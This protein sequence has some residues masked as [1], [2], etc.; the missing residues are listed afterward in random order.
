MFHEKLDINVIDSHIHIM[1]GIENFEYL[2]NQK[3]TYGYEKV[4]IL[5]IQPMGDLSQNAKCLAFKV[6][7]KGDFAFAGLQY[8]GDKNF[9]EQAVEAIKMGF[10]GFKMIEG[11]PGIRKM[12]GLALDS[13]EY[14]P[15]YNFLCKNNIP[16]TL[17][18]AD[19][20]SL[21]DDSQASEYAKE[22]GWVYTGNGFC[23]KE[24]I[25]NEVFGILNKHDGI[26]LILAHFFFAS[27]N[28]ERASDLLDR[29][30]NL[31]FDITPGIEMFLD[32]KKDIPGT[33]HFFEK[34]HKQIIFGTDNFDV[35]SKKDEEDKKVIN[36]TLYKFLCTKGEFKAWDL[37]LEGISLKPE[38]LKNILRDNFLKIT[39]KA[40]KVDLEHGKFYCRK[41]LESEEI[42]NPEN[43]KDVIYAMKMFNDE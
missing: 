21:W 26:N 25:E 37:D 13:N 8:S 33:K 12:T 42:K 38:I 11:K 22:Q 7:S 15:F 1:G 20:K 3:N 39:G 35:A 29:Y 30:P 31:S 34:Y 6:K 18:A 17:H 9:L 10:D 36:E 14:A 40:S 24:E 16:L 2:I 28:L 19:P 27:D 43:K 41:L 32:F 4:N 23:T 5:S